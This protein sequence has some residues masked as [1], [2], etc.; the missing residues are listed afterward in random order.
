[1]NVVSVG[2]PYVLAVEC[3]Y[4]HLDTYSPI[5]GYVARTPATS[6]VGTK[7]LLLFMC[8]LLLCA[9]DRAMPAARS[10]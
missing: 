4:Y 10:R 1:M 7:F 9:R 8:L 2:A 3:D 5:L 6:S